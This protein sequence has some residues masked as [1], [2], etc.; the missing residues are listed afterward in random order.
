MAELIEF[1]DFK[2]FIKENRDFIESNSFLH[3]N[4][5]RVVKLV[6]QGH[7]KVFKAFNVIEEGKFSCG[8]WAKDQILL[9]ASDISEAMIPLVAKGLE[10]EKIGRYQF[11]GTKNIIDC[12]FDSYEIEHTEQKHRKYYECSFVKQPFKYTKGDFSV[13]DINRVNEL[14]EFSKIFNEEFYDGQKQVKGIEANVLGGI[15]S[16]NLFQWVFEDNLVG[17]VDVIHNEYAF[18]VIGHVFIHPEFRGRGIASSITHKIT[19]H[20]IQK[21]YKNCWLMTN[22]YNP[23]SNRAFEKVGYKLIGEYVVRCK[24]K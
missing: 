12:L 22:A 1:T 15:E 13:A 17:M 5:I 19:N 23:A 16:Q 8:L 3:Y 11:F 9:Y 4:L 10:L 20:L 7:L 6:L 14:I 21:G 2:D 24:E 18:P